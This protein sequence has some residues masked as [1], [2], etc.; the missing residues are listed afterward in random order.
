MRKHKR[1]EQKVAGIASWFRGARAG[2]T[3]YIIK[4]M[5]IVQVELIPRHMEGLKLGSH[6]LNIKVLNFLV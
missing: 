1:A 3:M 4:G 2:Q 5:C 6:Y